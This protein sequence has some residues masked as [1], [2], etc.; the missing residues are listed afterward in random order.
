MSSHM[1]LIAGNVYLCFAKRIEY[2]LNSQRPPNLSFN[3]NN[4]SS[5]S[6]QEYYVV[7]KEC[8]YVISHYYSRFKQG[9]LKAPEIWHILAI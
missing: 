4:M 3:K 7:L 2:Y 5:I 6:W 8:F 1:H 9:I